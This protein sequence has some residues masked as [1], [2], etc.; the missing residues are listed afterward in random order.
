MFERVLTNG[1]HERRTGPVLYAVSAHGALLALAVVTP[2][3]A[4]EAIVEREPFPELV[5]SFPP[6]A[7]DPPDPGPPPPSAPREGVS[8][9]AE[10]GAAAP[11]P[12]LPEFDFDDVAEDLGLDPPGDPTSSAAPGAD[13]LASGTG[14]PGGGVDGPPGSGRHG[15]GT[16]LPEGDG[17]RPLIPGGAISTPVLVQKVA[18][19]YPSL[20]RLGRV[21]GRVTLRAVIAADGTVREVVVLASASPLLDAAAI[22]AVSGWRYRPAL[23][24]GRPVAVYLTVAVDFELR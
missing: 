7:P 20:A 12:P 1:A 9:P 22:E 19:V 4:V 21:S 10:G 18:P 13:Y 11:T 24:D 17:D 14:A 2:Y 15:R 5:V 23:W 16:R 3:F 8:G 6:V